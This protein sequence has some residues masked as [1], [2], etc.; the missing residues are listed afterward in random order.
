MIQMYFGLKLR[1]A[2]DHYD[3]IKLIGLISQNGSISLLDITN[4][5]AENS[6]LKKFGLG[7]YKP[8][9]TGFRCFSE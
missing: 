4:S 2:F 3:A 8:C 9:W 7:R 1:S 6:L 5:L